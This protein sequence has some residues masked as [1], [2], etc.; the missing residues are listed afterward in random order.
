MKILIVGDYG[1]SSPSHHTRWLVESARGLSRRGHDVAVALDGSEDL[2]PCGEIRT[3]IHDPRRRHLGGHP[4]SFQGW[5]KDV[6]REEQPE[7]VLSMTHLVP[8]DVHLPLGPPAARALSTI[9]RTTPIA[10]VPWELAHHA[11]LVPTALAESRAM[12]R[13]SIAARFGVGDPR[14][15][16]IRVS[17]NG[18][19][20]ETAALGFASLLEVPGAG[21]RSAWRARTRSLLGLGGGRLVVVTSAVHHPDRRGLVSMLAGLAS[22]RAYLGERTPTLLVL[23]HRPHEVSRLARSAGS[24]DLVRALN[25]TSEMGAILSAADVA[26][27]PLSSAREADR[28]ASSGRFIADAVRFGVPVLAHDAASG[29]EIVRQR[30][31]GTSAGWLLRRSHAAGWGEAFKAA[32]EHHVLSRLIEG[33]HRAAP[34]LSREGFLDRLEATLDRAVHALARRTGTAPGARSTRA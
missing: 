23:T 32:T 28:A 33:A 9:V 7:C 13:R 6:R 17:G 29:A 2:R 5:C 15:R 22:V 20:E 1:R 21:E 12:P 26:A 14:G 4:F 8:G 27:A 11:L 10:M 24:E 34:E 19:V 18:P 30:A 31:D 3:H 16:P 25:E